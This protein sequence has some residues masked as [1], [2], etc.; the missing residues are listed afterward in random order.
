MLGN[1]F[2]ALSVV[3]GVVGLSLL[4]LVF[5]DRMRSATGG[6]APIGKRRSS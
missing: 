3:G 6:F 2:V 5:R 1:L 4:V